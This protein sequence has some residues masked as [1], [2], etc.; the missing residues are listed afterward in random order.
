MTRVQSEG[1]RAARSL[2][3]GLG[4]ELPKVAAPA[5]RDVFGGS[6]LA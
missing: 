3:G 5:S 6:N 4:V 1:W 2:Q